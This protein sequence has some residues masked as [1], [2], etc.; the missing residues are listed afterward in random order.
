MKNIVNSY[1]R[2]KL[3]FISYCSNALNDFEGPKKLEGQLVMGAASQGRL[4]IR[5]K[6]LKD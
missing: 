2:R 4:N 3:Q 5:L 6:L 1:R